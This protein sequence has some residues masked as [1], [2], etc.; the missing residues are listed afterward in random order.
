MQEK[1]SSNL[2]FTSFSKLWT[3]L[4]NESWYIFGGSLLSALMLL[5]HG[6][7]FLASAIIEKT[8]LFGFLYSSLQTPYLKIGE[9]FLWMFSDLDNKKDEINC[10]HTQRILTFFIAYNLLNFGVF[11]ELFIKSL[12]T[13]N[14]LAN[15]LING[16]IGI[17]I[18]ST[19]FE[20]ID[21]LAD[22]I[23]LGINIQNISKAFSTKGDASSTT[24]IILS[25]ALGVLMIGFLNPA[26]INPFVSATLLDGML[27]LTVVSLLS[28]FP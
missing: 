28:Y 18:F 10:S 26:L 1:D 24:K 25:L 8:L 4:F 15:P 27:K 3:N 12:L 9:S 17:L 21:I 7:P 14:L 20:L 19:L 11:S 13:L 5:P 22:S 6:M 23:L 2:L 16:V